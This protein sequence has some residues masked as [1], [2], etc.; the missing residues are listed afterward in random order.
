MGC[1]TYLLDRGKVAVKSD[2]VHCI[3]VSEHSRCKLHSAEVSADNSSNYLLDYEV[4]NST[5][6]ES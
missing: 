6:S 4:M 2:G 5:D 1:R 3:F